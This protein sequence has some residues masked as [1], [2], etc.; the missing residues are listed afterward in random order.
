MEPASQHT[1]VQWVIASLCLLGCAQGALSTPPAE[2]SWNDAQIEWMGYEAGMATIADTQRPGVLVFY[3]T[4]CPHCTTYSALFHDPAIVQLAESF[5][6]IRVDRDQEEELSS[7]FG[8]FG[9]YIPRTL[10][11]RPDG[12][13]NESLRG[14][15]AGYPHFLLTDRPTELRALMERARRAAMSP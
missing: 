5:V 11:L 2:Q 6:M 15:N 7:R 12:Q 10:F 1:V 13:V 9:T 3:T 14:E 4:W 8:R